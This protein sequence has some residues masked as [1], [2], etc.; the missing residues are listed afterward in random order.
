MDE[1]RID[2]LENKISYQEYT[3]SQLD[4]IVCEQGELIANLQKRVN[5]LDKSLQKSSGDRQ[6]DPSQERPPH[7]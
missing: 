7:Y 3:I 2:E 1:K 5:Q 4:Q 6:E